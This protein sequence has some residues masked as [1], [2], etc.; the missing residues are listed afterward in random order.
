[1]RRRTILLGAGAIGAVAVGA[2]ALRPPMLSKTEPTGQFI[3]VEGQRLHYRIL[4]EGPKAIAVHGA[5]GNLMDWV[6][7][8]APRIAETHQILLFDRPGLGFSDRPEGGHDPFVQARLM[9]LAAQEL[10]FGEAILIGHSFGGSV[11][12]AWALAHPESITALMLL[13]A[14]SHVWE[15]GVGVLF[16]LS[17]SPITGP[18]LTRTIPRLVTEDYL[19]TRVGNIFTPQTAPEGYL[20]EVGV[21]LS[22]R[23]QTLRNNGRD[24][25]NLKP[26][27]RGMVERYDALTLPLEILHGTVD[28]IVPAQIHSD[29]LATRL[30][31]ARYT[32]LEGIGHMTH[33]VAMEAMLEALGRLQAQV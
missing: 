20:D 31:H 24:L 14:P 19:R 2:L 7:G 16:D 25:S 8:P 26:V 12:L 15:G 21:D 5:S 10:G 17:A 11:S 1:M 3:T 28:T 18:L 9:Y 6:L 32:R 30:P 29:K 23:P 27:I 13:S 33:H 22:L 4:G